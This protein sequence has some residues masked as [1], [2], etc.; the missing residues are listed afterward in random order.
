M[1]KCA[2]R[3]MSRLSHVMGRG[4]LGA[5]QGQRCRFYLLVAHKYLSNPAF[6]CRNLQRTS[7]PVKRCC[8]KVFCEGLGPSVSNTLNQ[9][10]RPR[11]RRKYQSRQRV[12]EFRG[13]HE[14]KCEKNEFPFLNDHGFRPNRQDCERL[15]GSSPASYVKRP[16]LSRCC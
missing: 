3:S 14:L 16:V 11:H 8:F 10:G 1:G 4:D 13:F 2:C 6:L 12:R 9:S 7:N 15:S 5:Q